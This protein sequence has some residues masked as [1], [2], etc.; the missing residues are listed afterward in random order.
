MVVIE[1]LLTELSKENRILDF[2][3]SLSFLAVTKDSLN[4]KDRDEI[5]NALSIVVSSELNLYKN[6]I[7]PIYS[8]Y[9]NRLNM[10]VENKENVSSYNVDIINFEIPEIILD[11][12]NKDVFVNG[13]VNVNKLI[14]NLEQTGTLPEITSL[15][16][17]DDS[18]LTRGLNKVFE[19]IDLTN[20]RVYVEKVLNTLREKNYKL[21][22]LDIL[23]LWIIVINLKEHFFKSGETL[24]I[25]GSMCNTIC[26]DYIKDT[27]DK[28][29]ITHIERYE[30]QTNLYIRNDI[31]DGILDEENIMDAILGASVY[32]D[33][34]YIKK[35]KFSVNEILVNKLNLIE[36]WDVYVTACNTS[37]PMNDRKILCNKIISIGLDLLNENYDIIKKYA[38]NITQL[39]FTNRVHTKLDGLNIIHITNYDKLLLDIISEFFFPETNF[40]RYIT[41]VEKYRLKDNTLDIKTITSFVVIEMVLDLLLSY[42]K[43]AVILP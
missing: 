30:N 15:E 38:N 25:L 18:I 28:I 32:K 23:R 14:S 2:K 6:I 31:L 9:I 4:V 24:S 26:K 40:D 19:G 36:A 34:N 17:P 39:D 7:L 43:T 42:T 37:N 27:E 29:L 11:L 21:M 12:Y 35:I 16:I 5:I 1:E 8:E 13:I 41:Y 10:V 33:E 20:L 22:P 3:D